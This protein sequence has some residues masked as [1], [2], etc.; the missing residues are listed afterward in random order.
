VN[1]GEMPGFPDGFLVGRVR[2]AHGARGL[3]EAE[4]D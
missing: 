3:V 4:D 2:V 1:E